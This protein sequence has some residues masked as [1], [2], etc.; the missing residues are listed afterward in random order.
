MF[1]KSLF[2]LVLSLIFAAG[3]AEAVNLKN[4]SG[5]KVNIKIHNGSSTTSTS[6]DSS[7]IRNDICKEC[8]IDV[9]GY[10]TAAASGNQTIIIKKDK[11][12]VK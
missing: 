4:E 2:L 10:G 5:K 12:E 1:K 11:L 8:K 6:I 3:S 9:E 7:T